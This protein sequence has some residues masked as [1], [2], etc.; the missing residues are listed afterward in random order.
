MSRRRSTTPRVPLSFR[1][2]LL[3]APTVT[4]VTR[5]RLSCSSRRTSHLGAATGARRALVA[6][7]VVLGGVV[8][9][10]GPAVASGT[11]TPDTEPAGAQAVDD[12]LQRQIDLLADPSAEL[13]SAQERLLAL[14][15]QASRSAREYRSAIA[16]RDRALGGEMAARAQAL[17]AQARAQ[18]AREQLGEYAASAYINGGTTANVAATLSSGSP[19]EMV[20]RRNSLSAVADTSTDLVRVLKEADEEA[21]A[22][23]QR[24][25][26]Q[27]QLAVV[28]SGRAK[29]AQ[30][31]AVE[32]A[33]AAKEL[34]VELVAT[35]LREQ[36][37]AIA[38]AVLRAQMAAFVS[39]DGRSLVDAKGV[40]LAYKEVG[41]GRIPRALLAPVGD[42]G[43]W[44]WPPAAAALEEL[45]AAAAADGIR[46][47]ITDSYRPYEV[48]VDL[49][50]RKGLYSQGGLAAT[51]GTSNHGWGTAV[52]LVLDGAALS[53]MRNNAVRFG[54]VEDVPREP[55][56]WHFLPTA[57]PQP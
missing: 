25:E 36:E 22:A 19:S 24:A 55:W 12:E 17:E 6:S 10:A 30:Q 42:T 20:S 1:D 34:L 46:I 16:E 33:E 51:P 21:R 39:T 8:S 26:A 31:R 47:G 40:P 9:A 14:T 32:S 48:Q 2:I 54:Y 18:A 27:A 44:L 41:N 13:L 7:L 4:G 56:H 38:E 35:E 45:L 57:L 5:T 53:W 29:L 52:D 11:P 50:A 15:E 28:A 23:R 3:A 49:V 43:H 37:Q